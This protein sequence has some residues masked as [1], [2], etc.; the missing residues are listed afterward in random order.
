[1]PGVNLESGWHD[2]LNP[3]GGMTAVLAKFPGGGQVCCKT[4][5]IL[6]EMHLFLKNSLKERLFGER[7][8]PG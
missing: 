1:M 6:T 8:Q 4:H 2:S 7:Y 5:E 3:L